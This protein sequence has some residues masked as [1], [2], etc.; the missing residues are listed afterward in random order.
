MS[1]NN[2]GTSP[3]MMA[4]ALVAAAMMMVFYFFV[5]LLAFRAF[6]F[7][8][9]ALIAW[10]KPLTLGKETIYPHEARAFVRRGLFGALVVPAFAVFCEVLLQLQIAPDAWTYLFVG[11]Y[12]G[13]SLGIEI[14]MAQQEAENATV[15]EY[16]P[17]V[18]EHLPNQ[19][20]PQLETRTNRKEDA[21]AVSDD[22]EARP[23]RFADW[24]DDEELK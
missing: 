16:F 10:N 2:N 23:F 4:F 17:P 5:A 1:S 24:D 20:R 8:I 19:H 14:L 18:V 9:L 3:E 11:G 13:G 15:S 7:T 21:N 6:V 22:A 12:V